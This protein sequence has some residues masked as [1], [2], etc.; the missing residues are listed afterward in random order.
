MN[1]YRRR[2]RN[3]LVHRPWPRVVTFARK[4]L[5]RSS[6]AALCGITL[7]GL[8]WYAIPSGVSW[9]KAHPYFAITKLDIEGNRRLTRS[10]VLE[11]IGVHEGTSIWLASP[12][13][14]QMRLESHPWVQRASVQREFPQHLAITLKERRPVAIV[15]LDVLNYVDRTGRVLGPLRDDDSRDFPLIT[16]FDDDAA[17]GFAPVGIRRAL[18]FLRRCDRL[19]CLGGISEV[20]VNA[21]RGITVFPQRTAVAVRLGWGG[22]REKL[23]RCGRALAAWDRQPAR[24]AA[25]DVSFRDV[26]VVKLRAEHRPAAVRGPKQSMRV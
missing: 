2:K 19:N 3:A 24:I 26:V 15:R 23:V 22:W 8:V 12:S 1:V 25:V 9:A 6:L 5:G 17:R 10:D 21:Q 20:Y 18:Q 11:W 13:L 7:A 4:W 16:G 14:L